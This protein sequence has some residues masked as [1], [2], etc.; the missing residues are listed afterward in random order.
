MRDRDKALLR[1]AIATLDSVTVQ[2]I[3][4]M[5]KLLGCVRALE[6]LLTEESEAEHG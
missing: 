2:G 4:N 1:A 5:E 6:R 3:D